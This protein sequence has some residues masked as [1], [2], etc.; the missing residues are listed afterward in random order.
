MALISKSVSKYMPFITL[1]GY[2]ADSMPTDGNPVI[3]ISLTFTLR[4]I[5]PEGRRP[6][7]VQTILT[8][9]G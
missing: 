4:T 9:D 1:E 6:Q 7:K 8:F 2:E 5:D 3:A